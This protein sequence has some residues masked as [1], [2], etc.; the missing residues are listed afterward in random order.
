V[1]NKGL[2]KLDLSGNSLLPRWF[3]PIGGISFNEGSEKKEDRSKFVKNRKPG[4]PVNLADNV[5]IRFI[6]KIRVPVRI[7]VRI[8]V[9]VD[10]QEKK[11][12]R[13]KKLK[14]RKRG[15]PV[16]LADNVRRVGVR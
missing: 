2:I 4:V 16:N 7:T 6:V 10:V 9:R 3:R 5:R 8:R 13:S 1:S 12:D 14:I 15:V 11:E